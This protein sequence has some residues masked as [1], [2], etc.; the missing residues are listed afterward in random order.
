MTRK[1]SMSYRLGAYEADVTIEIFEECGYVKYKDLDKFFNNCYFDFETKLT[2]EKFIKISKENLMKHPKYKEFMNNEV[3]M[4]SKCFNIKPL[5]SFT[6]RQKSIDGKHHY[7]NC[8]KREYEKNLYNTNEKLRIAHYNRCKKCAKNNPERVKKAK[9]KWYQS[10]KVIKKKVNKRYLMR[11][12]IKKLGNNKEFTKDELDRLV[13][14]KEE[15]N[16][17]TYKE[18]FTRFEGVINA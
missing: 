11:K 9:E 1:P 2:R 4:C 8:C 14:L 12:N 13:N 5:S 18:F 6:N 17:R 7:C 10:N 16:I 3:K 15:H